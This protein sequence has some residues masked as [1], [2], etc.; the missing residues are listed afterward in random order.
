A[1]LCRSLEENEMGRTSGAHPIPAVRGKFCLETKGGEFP[2]TLGSVGP[3][4]GAEGRRHRSRQWV[5][6][7]SVIGGRLPV[8]RHGRLLGRRCGTWWC[9]G[10]QG[11]IAALREGGRDA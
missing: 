8:L 1:G 6:L 5:A 3:R 2:K 10:F 9:V 4:E 7:V 11:F